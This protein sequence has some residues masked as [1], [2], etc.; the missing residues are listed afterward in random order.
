MIGKDKKFGIPKEE[1]MFH[2]LFHRDY[3]LEMCLL[4]DASPWQMILAETL[5]S[6]LYT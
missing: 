1:C 2:L 4:M 3:L 6:S 5:E